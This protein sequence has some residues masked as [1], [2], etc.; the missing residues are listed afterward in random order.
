MTRIIAGIHKG[1][2]LKVPKSVTRPTSSRVREAIF[3]ATEH[4]LSGLTELRLLDLYSGSGANALEAISRGAK[5]A[6]AIEKDIRAVEVIKANAN[7]LKISNLKAVGM[8][9]HVALN[10]ATQ[11]GKFDLVFIDPP[12]GL[13]DSLISTELQLLS[14]GWLND[15]ALIV[16]ERDKKSLF[17]APA[18]FEIINRKVYGDTSVWYGRYEES[19][20]LDVDA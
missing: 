16:V 6:V 18:A 11:F 17:E 5:E 7:S 3:S 1:R 8:D 20:R 13:A 19:E 9:V 12:Y 4:A 14:Q 2:E 10:G 15:G